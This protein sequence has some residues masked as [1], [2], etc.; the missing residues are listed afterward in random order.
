MI[1]IENLS[2]S[3]HVRALGKR[4]TRERERE[5]ER[6]RLGKEGGRTIVEKLAKTE[7]L[8]LAVPESLGA[9][10]REKRE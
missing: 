7:S 2:S 10:R 4:K 9:K 6:E 1:G 3:E 5:R 8:S